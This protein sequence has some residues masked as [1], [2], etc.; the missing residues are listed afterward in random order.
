[1]CFLAG[2]AAAAD[3][4]TGAKAVAT[5]TSTSTSSP[6]VTYPRPESLAD[7]R[8]SYPLALLK[9][10]L[11]KA[12]DH[13]R[14]AASPVRMQQGRSLRLLEQGQGIDVVWTV[15]SQARED[16][17]LPVRIP[18][19]RGLI[20]WR[21][22]LIRPEDRALFAPLATAAALA[23]LRAGQGHDW[24]DTDVL[25]ANGYAVY[26]SSSYE[27]LFKMLES[28]HVQYFPRAVTEIWKEIEARK[29]APLAVADGIVLHYPEALYFFVNK[30][31]TALA[32]AIEQGLRIAIADGAMTALFQRYYGAAIA[33]ADLAHRTVLTLAN[34]L[35]PAATP[36]ADQSL[37]FHPAARGKRLP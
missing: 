23:P 26:T 28:G 30:S 17:F 7:E 32:A 5:S 4:K 16:A 25:R 37:W 13:Y 27:R 10:S 12:G 3:V 24:P 20:G 2:G 8:A 34:P 36:L 33:R 9:L 18:I 15:T 22:L 11:K 21:L 6:D 35:L 1:M 19:D 29:D 31:N 14:L